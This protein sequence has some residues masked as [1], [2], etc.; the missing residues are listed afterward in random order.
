MG[1]LTL[2]KSSV[3]IKVS[4]IPAYRAVSDPKNSTEKKWNKVAASV[5]AFAK[6]T[7]RE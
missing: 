2:M 7:S 4:R 3:E 1:V 6:R 5:A